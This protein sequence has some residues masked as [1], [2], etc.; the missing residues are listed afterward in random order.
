MGPID[1]ALAAAGAS[2]MVGDDVTGMADDDATGAKGHLHRF[3]DQAPWH[4]VAVGVHIDGTVGLH[5]A[6]QIAQLAERRAGAK[7]A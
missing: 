1:D 4:R 5:P 3:S 6:D 7:W 2:R